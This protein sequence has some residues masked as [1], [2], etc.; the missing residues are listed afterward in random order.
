MG[1]LCVLTTVNSASPFIAH[2][3]QIL[4][5]PLR[6]GVIVGALADDNQ[7]GFCEEKCTSAAKVFKI[8]HEAGLAGGTGQ[9]QHSTGGTHHGSPQ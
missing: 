4:N 6:E 7:R 2:M 3:P 8:W 1:M 5:Y 9:Q